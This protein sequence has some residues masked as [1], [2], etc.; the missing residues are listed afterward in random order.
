[1][2]SKEKTKKNQKLF[3]DFSQSTTQEWKESIA[4]DSKSNDFEKKLVWKSYE[5]FSLQPF[6]TQ[7]D[8]DNLDY[9]TDSLPGDFPFVRGNGIK[10][11]NWDIC[12]EISETDIKKAN[13]IGLDSLNR[14]TDSLTFKCEYDKSSING[15]SIQ[16]QNDISVLLKDIPIQ[17]HT[18]NFIPG[19]AG[20]EI[21]SLFVSE[22]RNRNVNLYDLKGGLFFSPLNHLVIKGNLIASREDV[23]K[24]LGLMISF[25]GSNMPE[26]KGV[27]ADS[28]CFH[29]SGAT[30]VQELAF[31]IAMGVEYIAQLLSLGFSVDHVAN[32][33]LFS[34]SIG[35]NY[36][37]EIAKLRAARILWAKIVEQF[38]P[39][40][41]NSTRIVI[42]SKTS[43]WNKT[44]YDPYVNMLRGT[45]ESMAAAIGGCDSLTVG[46]LDQNYK[47]PDEFS[48]RLARN[49]QLVIKKESYLD[50]VID[51]A[52][53]SYYIENITDSI[54]N[55][56][57]KLFQEI[58]KQ[59]GFIEALK[60]GF[61]QDQIGSIKEI[62][63]RNIESRTEI[64]LGTNQYPNLEEKILDQ[65]EE[66][67]DRSEIQ[68]T[69][70][71]I[72]T[73]FGSVEGLIESISN[74]NLTVGDLIHCNNEE[75]D[76]EVVTLSPLRGARYFEELRLATEKHLKKNGS[77]P[78]VFLFTVGHLAMR[79]ARA[80]FSTNFFGCAGF[81]IID[82]IEFETVDDGVKKALESDAQIVVVCSSD[83]EYGEVA[84]EISKKIKGENPDV[85]VV[86]AGYPTDIV[87]DLK[88][89]GIDDFIHI[90]SNALETLFKYQ[91]L[92]GIS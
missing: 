89:S 65:I 39:K 60:S 19:I 56:S 78:R 11:N 76:F 85:F 55:E 75:T 14:G 72:D 3:K 20:L 58:E 69:N 91:K 62:K 4:K 15:V 46:T 2:S 9:L 24:K 28:S 54:A 88:N 25:L 52:S 82:N 18:I 61:I 22:A 8:L 37:I 6:Y 1:M 57:L 41:E 59:G 48:K 34:F 53:G 5:G 17:N 51:P 68:S 40:D 7:K 84:G 79:R 31:S 47:T 64:F 66:S 44:I 38:D 10:D 29:D 90:R 63:E 23:F 32:H 30:T 42:H 70:S 77:V 67:R 92:L 33:M 73:V 74:K 12:E 16:S 71:G 80:S 26:Y 27:V 87:D 81:E 83:Q 49:T 21:F 50:K 36:F 13:K 86:V 35:S 45:V 43:N